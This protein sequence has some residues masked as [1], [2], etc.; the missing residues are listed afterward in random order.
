MIQR[1]L[2]ELPFKWQNCYP[3][4]PTLVALIWV[5]VITGCSPYGSDLNKAFLL[6]EQNQWQ[7]SEKAISEAV[8]PDDSDVLL[9]QLERSVVRH[10]AEDW[11]GSNQLLEKAERLTEHQHELTPTEKLKTWM[12]NPRQGPYQSTRFEQVFVNYYKAL[13]YSLMAQH[14][15][16][17]LGERKT[18]AV[19]QTSKEQL[20]WLDAARVEARRIELKLARLVEEEGSYEDAEDQR[21]ELFSKVMRVLLVLV[22]EY[23]DRSKLVFRENAYLHYFS[24]L[25]YEQNGEF[26]NARIEYVKAAELYEGGYQAQYELAPDI[27]GQAWYD[28]ARM[29]VLAGGY[30]DRLETLKKDKLSEAQRAKLQ[31]ESKDQGQL[32]VIEHVGKV[33]QR[34]ELNFHL[35]AQQAFHT[36]ELFPILTG[37]DHLEQ[38]DQMDWFLL[39]Y[40]DLGA[41]E[42]LYN[43]SQEG[44]RGPLTAP[45]TKRFYLGNAW[46]LA[47]S[48]NITDAIGPL[49]VR[50]AVP[51]YRPL[52]TRPAPSQVVIGDK[53]LSMIQ[54]ESIA[55]LALQEQLYR[56][57]WDLRLAV[58]REILKSLVGN[59]ISR[60]VNDDAGALLIDLVGK[61][62]TTLTAQAET[63]N[64]LFLPYEIRIQRMSLPSGTH[65]V[66]L[67]S[68][69]NHEVRIQANQLT[70]LHYRDF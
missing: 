29:M 60:A 26:D 56:A 41:L 35:S 20:T 66:R 39:M 54:A 37:A 36:L 7:S 5:L 11:E 69:E 49:G 8:K 46:E 50:V 55:Q 38:Q 9:N 10:L 2:L 17:P 23:K 47:E 13:N 65:S 22:G 62:A 64:W 3:Q 45:F 25:M 42:I 19:Y 27:I 4:A 61:L 52:R 40:A 51:Y 44:I 28:A 15:A 67:S 59:T 21:Q 1:I 33:P 43:Y 58:A 31:L 14:A 16:L 18:S 53:K 6:A 24:G 57:H 12:T 63:R 32:V 70:F 68:G 34:Q 48:L 30:E